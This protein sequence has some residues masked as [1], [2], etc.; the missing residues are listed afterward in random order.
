MEPFA[1]GCLITPN[2]AASPPHSLPK[3]PQKDRTAVNVPSQKAALPFR[4]LGTSLVALVL[5]GSLSA[6]PLTAWADEAT[7]EAAAPEVAAETAPTPG[8]DAATDAIPAAEAAAAP[9]SPIHAGVIDA[10]ASLQDRIQRHGQDVLD[11]KSLEYARRSDVLAEQRA[12]D[13]LNARG[14]EHS[15]ADDEVR[16]TAQAQKE[17]QAAAE[18]EAAA[19][20]DQGS[21]DASA[22]STRTPLASSGKKATATA[23]KK[24]STKRKSMLHFLGEYIPFEQGDPTDTTAPAKTASTWISDGTVDDGENTYFIGHNPGVFSAVMDLEV[25]DKVTV[26]DPRGKKRTYYVFDTLTIP[27]ASNYFKYEGRIAP[28]GETITLQACCGDNKTVRC[29][30]AR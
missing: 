22:T 7:A 5:A 13:A 4:R 18:A 30:M 28:L 27:N 24:T 19:S 25:G 20:A 21:T 15:Q 16:A 3:K 10:M 9:T 14:E 12:L 1:R 11:E 26:W 29:V 17:E 6:A 2:A 23:K 8:T